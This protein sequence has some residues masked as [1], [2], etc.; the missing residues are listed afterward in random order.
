M[1]HTSGFMI[2]P[3]PSFLVPAFTY[4]SKIDD[5]TLPFERALARPSSRDAWLYFWILFRTPWSM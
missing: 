3:Q 4:V 5:P 2:R 1:C